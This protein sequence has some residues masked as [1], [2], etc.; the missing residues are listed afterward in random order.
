MPLGQR[1]PVIDG[2]KQQGSDANRDLPQQ[3][4]RLFARHRA[5]PRSGILNERRHHCTFRLKILPRIVP[6]VVRF[7][8][9]AT[10]YQ[11][12]VRTETIQASTVRH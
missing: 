7:F 8:P 1:I 2:G 11:H 4:G 10:P 6:T 3:P 12:R 9:C 5:V